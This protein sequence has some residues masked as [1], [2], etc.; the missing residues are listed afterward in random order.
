MNK[1]TKLNPKLFPLI[2]DWGKERGIIHV[3]N[4]KTQ[5]LK[6]V[7]EF[8]ELCGGVLKRKPEL[9]KDSIG[10]MIVVCIGLAGILED[11]NWLAEFTEDYV[12]AEYEFYDEFDACRLIVYTLQLLEFAE[13]D[14]PKLWYIIS[15]IFDATSRIA[16]IYNI[17]LEECL[18][19]AWNEIKDRQGKT[20][21]GN[22]IKDE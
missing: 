1:V 12:F 11:S 19:A 13:G 3:G 8:G 17:T 15:T 18:E 20:I 4:H 16:E 22:F 9:V 5:M 7:E 21:N 10:D 14:L 6:L 2:R